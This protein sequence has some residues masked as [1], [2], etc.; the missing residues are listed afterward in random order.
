[1]TQG[2]VKFYNTDKGYGM[3]AVDGNP[4]VFVSYRSIL[5]PG[6]PP[7]LQDGQYVEFEVR[8]TTKGYEAFNVRSI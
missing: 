6:S 3:I 1:M 7:T 4:D 2:V 5:D 8:Q